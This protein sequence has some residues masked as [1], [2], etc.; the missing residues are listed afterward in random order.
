MTRWTVNTQ[1]HRYTHTE[2]TKVK[3]L[4]LKSRFIHFIRSYLK[5]LFVIT[6][7]L[8]EIL[9]NC[10]TLS[11][12]I[13]IQSNLFFQPY[14]YRLQHIFLTTRGQ[15]RIQQLD[16][17]HYTVNIKLCCDIPQAD[18]GTLLVKLTLV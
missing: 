12:T 3:F 17:A 11:C 9:L 18:G 1:I 2:L 4:D 14:D 10:I 8:V 5:Y 15:Q 16:R 6:L 13:I 7:K